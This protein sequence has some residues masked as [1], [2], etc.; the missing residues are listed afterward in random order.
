MDDNN[1]DDGT[2][3]D[4]KAAVNM[5]RRF[6]KEN[7]AWD[8][9]FKFSIYEFSDRLD[10]YDELTVVLRQPT[11]RVAEIASQSYYRVSKQNDG[12][13]IVTLTS[14]RDTKNIPPDDPVFTE[15]VNKSKVL[16]LLSDAEEIKDI[17]MR[18]NEN[19]Y[20]VYCQPVLPEK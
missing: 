2:F 20:W 10:N 13:Y 8:P 3:I 4:H 6:I 11:Q 5:A 18:V 1:Q 16:K 7:T 14:A 12:S 19:I 15:V 9:K 17:G